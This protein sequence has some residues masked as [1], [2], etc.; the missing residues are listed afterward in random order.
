M[1]NDLAEKLLLLSQVLDG[2][3]RG[4]RPRA[5]T[6]GR[7]DLLIRNLQGRLAKEPR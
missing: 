2:I 1:D 4:E 5:D 3:L 7:L 6:L